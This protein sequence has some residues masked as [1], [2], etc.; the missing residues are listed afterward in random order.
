[1]CHVHKKIKL[2]S[3]ILIPVERI[4]YYIHPIDPIDRTVCFK[5]KY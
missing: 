2:F 1:M 4:Q 5:E 3:E